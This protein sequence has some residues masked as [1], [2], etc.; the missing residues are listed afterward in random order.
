MTSP[1][2]RDSSGIEIVVNQASDRQLGWTFH[3]EIDLGSVEN[4]A[5][6]FHSLPEQAVAFGRDGRLF[7]LDAGNQRVVA[8]DAEGRHLAI[9][10]AEGEG[11]GHFTNPVAIWTPPSG[12]TVEVLDLALGSIVRFTP[13]GE[14]LETRSLTGTVVG[15]GRRVRSTVPGLVHKRRLGLRD[16]S[17]DS[18][19]VQLIS[20]A[21]TDTT[22]LAT[23]NRVGTRST[24]FPECNLTVGVRPIFDPALVWDARKRR[25]AVS[26]SIQ[27]RVTVLN[28]GEPVREIRRDVPAETVDFDDAVR[29]EKHRHGEEDEGSLELAGCPIP[30]KE[31]VEKSGHRSRLQV[32]DKIRIDPEGRLWV[33]RNAVAGQGP[34]DVF[35]PTGAYLGTLPPDAPYPVAFASR[36]RFATTYTDELD[37]PHVA[38]YRI[39]TDGSS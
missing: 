12:N 34:I 15:M 29:E 21:G 30:W 37:V 3:K 14:P 23:T 5:T 33:R 18:I 28:E 8:F 16:Y 39:E 9:F 13:V 24:R 22:V 6:A 20:A 10:G 17:A 26:T 4:R 11:P 27:Y 25:A 31:W 35:D 19:S 36:S 1:F 2:R 38:V 32:V 7:V